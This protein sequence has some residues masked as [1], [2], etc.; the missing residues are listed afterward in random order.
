M[1]V[2]IAFDLKFVCAKGVKEGVECIESLVSLPLG[3]ED[4]TLGKTH[5]I[6][7]VK[8]EKSH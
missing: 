1:V 6:F 8:L 3:G 5:A 4:H 7:G 2:K